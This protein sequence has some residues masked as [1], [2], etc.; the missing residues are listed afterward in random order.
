MRQDMYQD[1]FNPMHADEDEKT[2]N[3]QERGV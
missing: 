2:D 3:T 1:P